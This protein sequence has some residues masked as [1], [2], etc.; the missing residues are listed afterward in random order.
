MSVPN[1]PPPPPVPCRRARPPGRED[2]GVVRRG[3]GRRRR[4]LP[5][6]AEGTSRSRSPARPEQSGCGTGNAGTPSVRR[7][8]RKSPR[9]PPGAASDRGLRRTEEASRADE[10]P[11]FAAVPA[12][13]W[14]GGNAASYERR[15]RT[16]PFPHEGKTAPQRATKRPGTPAFPRRGGKRA[17]APATGGRSS[18][19][20]PGAAEEP[21]PD[22]VTDPLRTERR[23]AG[24][25]DRITAVSEN[26]PS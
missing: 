5:P 12:A 21:S 2:S 16:P 15:A 26:S 14:D 11:W 24:P 10:T 20:L 22:S 18:R 8:G 25:P 23:P 1:D 4:P 3:A 9:S 17:R 6:D 7:G 13:R 19:S